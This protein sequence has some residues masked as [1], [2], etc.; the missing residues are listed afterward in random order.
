MRDRFI[1]FGAGA[2][3]AEEG[4]PGSLRSPDISR[5]KSAGQSADFASRLA[6]YS[7][8]VS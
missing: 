6:D 7:Q 5:Q 1:S 2:P 3:S 8:L 4:F